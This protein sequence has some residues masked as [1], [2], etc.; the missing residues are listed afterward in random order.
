MR[1]SQPWCLRPWTSDAST[2]STPFRVKC[3]WAAFC[4]VGAATTLQ[5]WAMVVNPFFSPEIRLQSERGHRL[6]TCGPYR[7]LRHPGYLAMLISVPASALAIGSWLALVPA[8]AFCLVILKR[9]GAE[10]EFLQKNL[11]G[12]SDYM[13]QVRG[14]L[15]PRI[16]VRH[17]S[18]RLSVATKFELPTL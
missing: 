3:A 9:V 14:R 8:A 4:S 17:R 1:S 13:R 12:Y 5:L 11:A 7:F 18:H 15:F 16:A 6:V 2:G 10:E